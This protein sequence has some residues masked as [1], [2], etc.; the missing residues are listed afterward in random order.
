MKDQ[1]QYRLWKDADPDVAIVGAGMSG[2]YSAYRLC[3]GTTT[4]EIQVG[5]SPTAK[6]KAVHFKK[7]HLN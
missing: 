7:Q 4:G 1:P 5:S 6:L 3:T 2:L